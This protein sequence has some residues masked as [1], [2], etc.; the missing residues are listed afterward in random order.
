MSRERS[1]AVSGSRKKSGAWSGRSRSGKKARSASVLCPWHNFTGLLSPAV[2]SVYCNVC[3]TPTESQINAKISVAALFHRHFG[4]LT[5]G[6][7]SSGICGVVSQTV[8]GLGWQLYTTV[9]AGKL[10]SDVHD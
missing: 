6:S 9:M 1:G 4:S 7:A 3:V 8:C 5:F 2:A 10:T